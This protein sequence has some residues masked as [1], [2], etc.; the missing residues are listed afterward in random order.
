M[1]FVPSARGSALKIVILFLAL[2]ALGVGGWFTYKT[3]IKSPLN[4]FR[5]KQRTLSHPMV[6]RRLIRSR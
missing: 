6:L 3:F 1:P 5:G 4:D 2:A